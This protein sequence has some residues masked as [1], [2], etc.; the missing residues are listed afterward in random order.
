[1][2]YRDDWSLTIP[3]GDGMF[4]L[5]DPRSGVSVCETGQEYDGTRF[6]HVVGSKCEYDQEDCTSRGWRFGPEL[7]APVRA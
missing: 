2:T 4:W 6:V 3:E 1:M 5:S 7:L